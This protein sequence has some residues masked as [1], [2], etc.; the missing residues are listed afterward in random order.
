M[1]GAY[2]L[3][4]VRTPIGRERGVLA[5][6]EPYRLAA[7]ALRGALAAAPDAGAVEAVVLANAV[8]GGNPARV[9]ALAAG[10][11]D[12]PALTVN[13]QCVGGLTAV[14]LAAG[15]AAAGADLA[16]AGGVESATHA[17]VRL[18]GRAARRDRRGPALPRVRHAPEGLPD[19]E[20][21]PAADLTAARLG[22]DRARQD[23]Y[24]CESYRRTDRARR[25]GFFRR[26]TVPVPL[27]DGT[28]VAEDESPRRVPRPERL[29]RYPAAFT[30]GGTVTAGN[31]AAVGDGAAAV[32][33]GSERA[34]RRG[35]RPLARVA[36]ACAAAADP[37]LPALAAVPAVE[38]ALAAAG[39]RP[40]DVDRWEVNE[41][42]AVKV[43]ALMDR[44][45]LDRGRVNVNGGAIAYGHPFAAS[46]AV[47]VAHLAAELH[48][49]GGRYGV[50]AIAGAGGL[51][52]AVVLERC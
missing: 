11:P 45:G 50:A 24:A 28:V 18:E 31:C 17:A 35:L 43:L 25:W 19:P 47:L 44:L 13:S 5:A 15:L 40:A 4:A 33:V 16:L 20:M 36:A 30:P 51:G 9:A 21:G 42:F 3:S 38:R 41:A 49:S 52:E 2:V 27:P 7:V 23:A 8:N 22:I 32:L 39:L 34:L 10:L 37:A 6:L 14:R 29:A 46:G 1:T 48:A 26:V 12:T